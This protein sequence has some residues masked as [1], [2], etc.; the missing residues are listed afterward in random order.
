MSFGSARA[1]PTV[2]ARAQEICELS[3]DCRRQ[4]KGDP[5]KAN[6][7]IPDRRL[8]LLF[9]PRETVDYD[10]CLFRHVSSGGPV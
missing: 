6:D 3:S 4:V 5:G 8:V 2:G 1:I 10:A 7:Q 9:L